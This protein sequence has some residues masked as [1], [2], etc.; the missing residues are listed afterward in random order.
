M[1]EP[2]LLVDVPRSRKRLKPRGVTEQLRSR[3]HDATDATDVTMAR[4]NFFNY[5]P[6]IPADRMGTRLDFARIAA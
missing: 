4:F 1:G 2:A 3:V 6:K 5:I